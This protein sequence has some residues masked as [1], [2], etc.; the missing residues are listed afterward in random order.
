[1]FSRLDLQKVQRLFGGFF[2]LKFYFDPIKNLT[3]EL[4][5]VHYIC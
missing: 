2:I 5:H 1:M 4:I 3:L